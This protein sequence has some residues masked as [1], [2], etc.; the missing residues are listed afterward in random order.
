MAKLSMGTCRKLSQDTTGAEIAE[1]AFV[2]PLVF[3]LL[4]GILWF[5]RA[6]HIYSTVNRAAREAAE[7]AAT[8]T[9]ATCGNT[10]RDEATIQTSVVNPILNAAHLDPA[11]VQN[12]QLQQNVFLNTSIPRETGVTVSFNYPYNFKLN[13]VTCCPMMLSPINAGITI[14]AEGQA[15][16]EQ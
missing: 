16:M 12:F 15:R 7:A 8:P 4:L 5:G 10:F 2:L 1:A 11:Q 6:F 9:C 13:G 14:H 3:M